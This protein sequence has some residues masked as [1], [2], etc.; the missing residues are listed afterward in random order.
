MAIE[1]GLLMMPMSSSLA[2]AKN[3]KTNFKRTKMNLDESAGINVGNM[4]SQSMSFGGTRMPPK[5]ILAQKTSLLASP[6]ASS[7]CHLYHHLCPSMVLILPPPSK[8]PPVCMLLFFALFTL[9]LSFQVDE[10]AAA[11][12]PSAASDNSD[13]I[14]LFA[15]ARQ[16][17]AKIADSIEIRTTKYGIRGIVA[18]NDIPANT[19]LILIPYHLQLGVRQLAEG[20]D[21]EMQELARNLPWEYILENELSFV[22]L[23]VA[24]IA[25][26]RKGAE[27]SIFWP[28]LQTLP[29]SCNNAVGAVLS[30][31]EDLKDI[32]N[33]AP[34][35][36]GKMQRRRIGIKHLHETLAPPSVSFDDLRW[37]ATNV[38]SR[39]LVRKRIMELSPDEI[40]RVG[41]FAASDRSRMLPIIDMVNHGQDANAWVGHLSHGNEDSNDFSTSLK[42]LRDIEAGEELLFDYGPGGGEK[43]SNDRL[44]LDYGF[45]LPGHTHRVSIGFEELDAAI[46]AL[47][48]Y[49]VGMKDVPKKDLEGLDALIK[50]LYKQASEAQDGA[51]LVFVAGEPSVHTLAVAAAMACRDHADVTR[52]LQP[53]QQIQTN[54]QY[55]ASLLSSEVVESCTEVQKEFARF[56]LK[57]AADM[58]LNK[59]PPVSE[60]DCADP[61]GSAESSSF[62]TNVA[63]EYS[64]MCREMLKGVANMER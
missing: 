11:S 21:E 51:P 55:D 31:E 19:E 3:N 36:V 47:N 39:G 42:S 30:G 49:R 26:K 35:V 6:A 46:S 56:V 60:G 14:D 53:V 40:K 12:N 28:F 5:K 54:G 24:L 16:H 23:S 64:T 41:E 43:I 27:N 2:V 22:P 7:R 17:G 10:R 63:R 15:W 9:V 57:T 62:A 38:C 37:A 25:E 61:G 34:H 33:W 4:K 32:I 45:V 50:F 1:I 29:Q 8:L 13:A 20:N 58:A 48:K 52:V 44:L 59:R 18:K